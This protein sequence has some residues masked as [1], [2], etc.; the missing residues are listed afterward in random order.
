M[1]HNS[2]RTGA[3]AVLRVHRPSTVDLIATELRNAIYSGGLPTGS[4][5]REVEIS[6]QLG[7]SRSPL[8]EAAQRLVQE[9]LLTAIPGQGLRVASVGEDRLADLFEARIAVESHAAR[10]LIRNNDDGALTKVKAAFDQLSEA[11][12]GTDARAIGDADLDFHFALVDGAGN[13]RLT[14]YMST[15]VVETRLAS[16]SSQDGYVVR[17]E[18]TPTHRAIMAALESGDVEAATAAIAQHLTEA[19]ARMTGKLA[20]RGIEVETVAEVPEP[21]AIYELEP[22]GHAPGTI[23]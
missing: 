20:E 7:V 19:V 10:L 2:A 8:R 22:I 5:L 9:G 21:G 4:P 18:I 15:L 11:V 23:A 1:P 17:R 13:A 6:R 12:K 3:P 16:F 14:R